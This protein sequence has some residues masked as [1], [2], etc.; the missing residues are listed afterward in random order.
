MFSK[1]DRLALTFK[2]VFNTQGYIVPLQKEKSLLKW[3]IALT[4]GK[5][6]RNKHY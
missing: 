5:A 4:S 6:Q 3:S 1:D 2:E